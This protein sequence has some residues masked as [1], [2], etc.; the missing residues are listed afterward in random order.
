MRAAYEGMFAALFEW[1]LA[2]WSG[3]ETMASFL[4]AVGLGLLLSMNGLATLGAVILAFGPLTSVPHALLSLLGASPIAITYMYF[5]YRDRW[6]EVVRRSEQRP[7]SVRRRIRLATSTY[8]ALTFLAH[9]LIGVAMYR[10]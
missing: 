6:V 1:N 10:R 3:N 4:T 7:A 2:R 8:V 5:M 9:V